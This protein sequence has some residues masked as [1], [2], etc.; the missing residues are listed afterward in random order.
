M[1]ARSDGLAQEIR[2]DV[3]AR[4]QELDAEVRARILP[5][6]EEVST[7]LAQLTMDRIGRPAS[8]PPSELEQVLL[9]RWRMLAAT[10]E[11]ELADALHD[12]VERTVLRLLR[13]SVLAMLF[14]PALS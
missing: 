13:R 5:R 6:V 10:L 14:P 7:L 3:L 2:A 4:F 11:L 1:I 8:E 12:S 9:A